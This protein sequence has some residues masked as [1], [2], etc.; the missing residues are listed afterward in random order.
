MATQRLTSLLQI[1]ILFFACMLDSQNLKEHFSMMYVFVL[2]L[3]LQPPASY[4]QMG[5]QQQSQA[6]MTPSRPP[7]PNASQLSGWNSSHMGS[8]YDAAKSSYNQF[9]Q[10]FQ[11]P[12][13][14]AMQHQALEAEKRRQL[15][16]IRQEQM[17]QAQSQ[18]NRS[19]TEGQ[20]RMLQSAQSM[21]SQPQAPPPPYTTHPSIST[22]T[23]NETSQ[24]NG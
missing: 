12:S 16:R 7:N 2:C 14:N 17:I 6:H 18:H 4:N 3:I 9:S 20:L 5:S 23:V 13:S 22:T 8:Q 21:A 15:L 19:I 11:A 10:N 1:P 24:N